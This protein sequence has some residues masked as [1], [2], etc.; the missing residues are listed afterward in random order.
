MSSLPI[1]PLAAY[2]VHFLFTTGFQAFD[3]GM[4]IE[5][6]PYI[7]T[8]ESE[9][10]KEVMDWVKQEFPDCIGRFNKSTFKIYCNEL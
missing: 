2:D 4:G 1:S 3:P 10:Y 8:K 9:I 7:S 6:K 5:H